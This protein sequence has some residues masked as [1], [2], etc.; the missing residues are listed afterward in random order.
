MLVVTLKAPIGP[1]VREGIEVAGE[2]R[3]ESRPES[4][5]E[6]VMLL[7]V[8]GPLSKSEIASRLG[9]KQVSGQLKKT[10]LSLAEQGRIEFTIPEKPNSRLQRYRLTGRG[11]EKA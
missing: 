5:A 2:S 11:Q 1:A 10:L 3:P 7:L 9:Q 8:L 4:V 6:R